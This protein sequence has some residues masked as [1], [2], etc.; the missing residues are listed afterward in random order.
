LIVNR[1]RSGG[2]VYGVDAAFMSLDACGADVTTDAAH[3][4]AVGIA[5]IC[6]PDQGCRYPQ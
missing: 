4:A 2:C 5:D 6:I 1:R 3:R